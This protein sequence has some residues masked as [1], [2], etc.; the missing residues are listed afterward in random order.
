MYTGFSPPVRDEL[1]NNQKLRP[2]KV[3]IMVLQVMTGNTMIGLFIFDIIKVFINPNGK[4]PDRAPYVLL[5]ARTCQKVHYI[6]GSACGK[7]LHRV[8]MQSDR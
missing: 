5:F 6:L 8:D 7:T 2:H 4:S 3:A 1:V